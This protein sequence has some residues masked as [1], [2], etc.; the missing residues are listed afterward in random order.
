M[1]RAFSAL[2]WACLLV[3]LCSAPLRAQTVVAGVAQPDPQPAGLGSAVPPALPALP[4]PMTADAAALM[5]VFGH[6]AGL[7]RIATGFGQ[8]MRS[9]S[10]TARFF[11][12]TKLPSLANQLADQF[13]QVLGGPCV[14]EGDT[15]KASHAD[16]GIA[17]ADFLAA[18][19]LLQAAMDANGI[20]FAAQ[21]RL[22]A[23]LAPMH[24]D[25]VTVR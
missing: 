10:R 5:E 19:E 6:R 3:G 21:N 11:A 2:S 4:A 9:D 12:N 18:V 8:R 14:Y 1:K 20:P 7:H 17:R 24:R 13:C 22:L 15:M 25:I 16:L 23:R